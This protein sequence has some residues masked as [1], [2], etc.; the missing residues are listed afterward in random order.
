MQAI[1]CHPPSRS[2][3]RQPSCQA[4]NAWIDKA[5]A[6]QG[7]YLAI[8]QDPPELVNNCLADIGFLSDHSVVFVVRVVCVTH[9]YK[10]LGLVPGKL[11]P[12]NVALEVK[13]Q[14]YLTPGCELKL[15][16]F[17]TKLALMPNIVSAVKLALGSSH[18]SLAVSNR[19]SQQ[20]ARPEPL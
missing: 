3:A 5:T 9:L 1:H 16:K 10:R 12:D 18:A 14:A 8:Q 6:Q 15:K 4:I 17:V 20:A 2:I 19:L 11:Q 7:V 13:Q